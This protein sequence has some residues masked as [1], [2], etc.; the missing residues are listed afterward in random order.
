MSTQTAVRRT[1]HRWSR[2]MLGSDSR[3]SERY[4]YWEL[5]LAKLS[6]ASF[7][8]I[9]KHPLMPPPPLEVHQKPYPQQPRSSHT[10]PQYTE[11]YLY[12]IHGD[13]DFICQ[14]A[15]IKCPVIP[16]VLLQKQKNISEMKSYTCKLYSRLCLSV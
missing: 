12:V 6:S 8:K 2:P 15:I 4:E 7:P 9:T 14:I 1:P 5:E 11:V 16:E 3:V 10:R 13:H